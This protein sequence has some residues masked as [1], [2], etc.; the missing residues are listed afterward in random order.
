M[1]SACF[2]SHRSR[3]KGS[4]NF[5]GVVMDQQILEVAISQKMG[6]RTYSN[7]KGVSRWMLGESISGPEG[8]LPHPPNG[9]VFPDH[10]E[11]ETQKMDSLAA[12]IKKKACSALFNCLW[13]AAD[14]MI[15]GSGNGFL[16]SEST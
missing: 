12:L 15:P 7:K 13:A 5:I 10:L 14:R 11:L 8:F 16:L 1:G 2:L 9:S 3:S 6:E 4:G